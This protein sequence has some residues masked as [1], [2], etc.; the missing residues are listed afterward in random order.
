MPSNW[1]LCINKAKLFVPTGVLTHWK[2][3][4]T[5]PVAE[6]Q[7]YKSGRFPLSLNTGLESVI[8]DEPTLGTEI[9]LEDIL[10]Y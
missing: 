1:K 3:G 5:P 6:L 7:L 10:K 4:F 9:N 2:G 8:V